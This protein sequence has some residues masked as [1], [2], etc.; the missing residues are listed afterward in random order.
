ML[1]KREEPKEKR[2]SFENIGRL[3]MG[4][5]F[6]IDFTEVARQLTLIDSANFLRIK[7]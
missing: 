6:T 7:V 3:A 5:I 4:D 2:V 1:P